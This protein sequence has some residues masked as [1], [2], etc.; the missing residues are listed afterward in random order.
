MTLWKRPNQRDSKGSVAARSVEKEMNEWSTATVQS[1]VILNDTVMV[2]TWQYAFLKS[3]WT[4][5]IPRVNLNINCGLPLIIVHL[6]C[7]INYINNKYA[8]VM[9]DVNSRAGSQWGTGS[10]HLIRGMTIHIYQWFS[11]EH[12]LKT[13]SNVWR[14]VWLLQL[15]EWVGVTGV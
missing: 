7:F 3:H 4:Q 12:P 14:H 13:L 2:S 11:T 15:G 9:Q 6:Y 5:A 8:T 10:M 1:E